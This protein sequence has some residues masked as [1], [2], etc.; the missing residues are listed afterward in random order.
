M[1][2]AARAGDS[3][4]RRAAR[5]AKEAAPTFRGFVVSETRDLPEG[6]EI[7]DGHAIFRLEGHASFQEALDLGS[8]AIVYCRE[9]GIGRLLIDATNLGGFGLGTS[10]LFTAGEQLA[11]HAMAAVKIA[12]VMRTEQIDPRG[13][14]I[15]VA[16]NRGLFSKAF[17]SEAEAW[18]WLLDPNAE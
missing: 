18:K 3:E 6:L 11:R 16:R 14:G 10:E 9:N 1:A 13:V 5:E 2:P 7:G 15:M 4:G 12:F 17:S 8:R